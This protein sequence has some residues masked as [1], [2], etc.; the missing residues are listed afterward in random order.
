MLQADYMQR[1]LLIA[2]ANIG[3]VIVTFFIFSFIFSGEW[4]HKIWEKYISSFAK[5][6]VYIF[7]VSLIINIITAWAVY[8][9][10]LDRYINVIVPM[11]QSIIIGF[12]AACV[13]RRGVE[14]KRY[15]EK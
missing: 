2:L 3:I 4:R 9:L 14:Y 10:Q 6:V 11:V 12:V 13:P 15:S 8:A 7:I 1:L 5:F